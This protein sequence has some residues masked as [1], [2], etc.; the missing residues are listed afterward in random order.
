LPQERA[1]SIQAARDGAHGYECHDC[2]YD[3][4][5]LVAHANNM[6]S[7]STAHTESVFGFARSDAQLA[8]VAW[9]APLHCCNASTACVV[10][11]SVRAAA[12]MIQP[13][14]WQVL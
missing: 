3:G 14:L 7:E 10:Q 9:L 8:Q 6:R 2:C 1:F 13:T 5:R 12:A 4:S 11:L